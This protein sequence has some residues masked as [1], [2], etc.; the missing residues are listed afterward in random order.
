LGHP[1]KNIYYKKFF[2]SKTK[3]TKSPERIFVTNLNSGKIAAHN[4]MTKEYYILPVRAAD[5]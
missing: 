5:Y 3:S 1:F 2:W 4:I